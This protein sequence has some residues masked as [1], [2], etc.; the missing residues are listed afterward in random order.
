MTEK[1]THK[2]YDL[3]NRTFEFAKQVRLFTKGL[4]HSLSNNED[5]KQAMRSSGSVGANYIAWW[6]VNMLSSENRRTSPHHS[7]KAC[8]HEKRE[9]EYL[10]LVIPDIFYRESLPVAVI[11]DILYRESICAQSL[12]R[13]IP[14]YY[15][16]GWQK[17]EI[18][19]RYKLQRMTPSVLS[20]LAEISIIS[21]GV[22]QLKFLF[23][24]LNFFQFG[25]L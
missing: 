1:A 17:S 9:R 13:W 15:L 20:V 8:T 23:L 19:T 16:R 2:P 24:R 7:R 14:A 18:D 12:Q 3:E 6:M 25:Q 11:P 10:F 22:R 4:K 5:V 21:D